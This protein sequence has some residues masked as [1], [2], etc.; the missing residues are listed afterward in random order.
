MNGDYKREGEGEGERRI[1]EEMKGIN[2]KRS[3]ALSTFTSL[4]IV[5]NPWQE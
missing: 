1:G 2:D 5:I 3:R 4:I